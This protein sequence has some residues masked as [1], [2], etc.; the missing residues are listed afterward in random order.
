M[1]KIFKEVPRRSE[2]YEERKANMNWCPVGA[3]DNT[4]ACTTK[5]VRKSS[6]QLHQTLF[7]VSFNGLNALIIFMQPSYFRFQITINQ[8]SWKQWRGDQ[9]HFKL[10]ILMAVRNRCDIDYTKSSG[11]RLN[12]STCFRQCAYADVSL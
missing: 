10:L 9:A 5:P 12:R 6:D 8:T 1:T 11:L 2:K 7:T 4:C 3:S